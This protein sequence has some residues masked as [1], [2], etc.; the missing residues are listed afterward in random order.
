MFGAWRTIAAA[1]TIVAACNA[2]ETKPVATRGDEPRVVVDSIFPVE[3]EI[4]RFK[5]ARNGISADGLSGG[6]TSR[7]ALVQQFISALENQDTAALRALAMHAGEYIDLYYP[8]SIYF[9]PPYKQSPE[10][11]WFLMQENDNKGFMRLMQRYSGKPTGFSGYSCAE[12]KAEGSNR[13]HDRC[14]VHWNLQPSP[15]RIFSTI[16]ER[17]G[18]FKFMSYANGM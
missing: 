3:E 11:N 6:S 16:I 17:G 4:R 9:R 1:T 2:G 12:I 14:V 5:A 13:I 18:Q 10:L 15:M 8:T 7:D